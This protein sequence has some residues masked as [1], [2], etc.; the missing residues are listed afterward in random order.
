MK[1]SHYQNKRGFLLKKWGCSLLLMPLVLYSIHQVYRTLHFNIFFAINYDFPFP[2]NI[3]TF[4]VDN[5]L[6]IVHEAGHTFFS[7]FGF[8]TLT[9]LGGSLFQ[10][11]LPAFIL[12]YCWFNNQKMG[13]QLSLF[14]TGSSF[15]DVAFY[16]ADALK[17]QL[18]LIGGLPKEAHDWYNLLSQWNLLEY[19]HV[20]GIIIASL[21]IICYLLALLVPIFYQEYE[22]VDLDL[23]LS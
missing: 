1:L 17:R 15:I 2:I 12:G 20:I 11:L 19:S 13:I 7:V 21:G 14:L 22:H 5:F 16:A 8:R 10:I 9:I 23:N 18:P 3:I 6:L 4:F